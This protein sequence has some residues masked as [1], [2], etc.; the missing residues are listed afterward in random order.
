MPQLHYC[1]PLLHFH[2]PSYAFA[3]SHNISVPYSC[4]FVSLL[5]SLHSCYTSATPFPEYNS[6]PLL[7]FWPFQP[8]C[9]LH[10]YPAMP[11]LLSISRHFIP[12]AIEIHHYIA[13]HLNPSL[14]C[15]PLKSITILLAIEIHH[16]ISG[17]YKQTRAFRSHIYTAN[18]LVNY[19]SI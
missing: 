12:V 17:P 15:W 7:H 13:G 6:M 16:Y 9:I 11:S 18:I 10:L 5:H 3:P 19:L 1:A 8:S 4:T 2:A 14:Y